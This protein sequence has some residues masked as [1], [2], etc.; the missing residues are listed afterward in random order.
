MKDLQRGAAQLFPP[1]H[2]KNGVPANL[3]RNRPGAKWPQQPPDLRATQEAAEF[4]ERIKARSYSP[5][6]TGALDAQ[7]ERYGARGFRENDVATARLMERLGDF[8]RQIK[9][10]NVG[11]NQMLHASKRKVE[12]IAK[13]RA[14]A[15]AK[16]KLKA[17]D[18]HLRAIEVS[19]GHRKTPKYLVVMMY[20]ALH[21]KTFSS[22]PSPRSRRRKKDQTLELRPLIAA[23]HQA[24]GDRRACQGLSEL[25]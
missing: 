14:I 20:G 25:H 17:F 4:E 2:G 6:F 11:D 9:A 10:I 13:M 5:A 19:Y 8:F 3:L 15:K 12:A 21:P 24:D 23:N 22:C 18:R 16:G 7:I 1:G